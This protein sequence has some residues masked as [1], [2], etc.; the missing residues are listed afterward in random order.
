[1]KCVKIADTRKLV[2]S[3]ME[4]N[5]NNKDEVVGKVIKAGICGSDIHYWDIGNP[6]GLVMGHEFCCE[7]LRPGNRY[8]LKVGDRFTA[9]P[10]SPCGVCEACQSGNPQ[11]CPNT[12]HDAVGL[13]LS[14]PGAFSNMLS[15][16]SDLVIKVPD[17]VNDNEVA[18]VEPTAVGY[19]A[20]NLAKI[21]EGSKVL[22]IG[23]GIIGMV[24]AMF[25]KYQ[26]ACFVAVSEANLKRGEKAIKLGVADKYYNALDKDVLQ[27]MLSDTNNYGFD[28]V[29]DC[30]GNAPAVTTAFL[31]VKPGGTVVLVGVS[32]N[33]I[34][35]PTS[36]AVTK[37]LTVLGAIAYKKEEFEDV[38]NMISD[39]KIDVLRF[40]D[41]IVPL[42]KAQE[43]FERLTNGDDDA[44][45]ILVD[46]NM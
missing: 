27:E 5:F 42:E 39:K 17:N 40:V 34:T 44:I 21:K 3:N 32:L 45:K 36:L 13:S 12:W 31:A 25:A 23:A 37:E 38:I 30:C 8:D 29:I 1:M 4:D 26:K 43:S 20:I 46:P 19:H 11:Y 7:V 22:V 15:V 28:Y 10:I 18:M 33:P 14:H 6:N 16:R 41:D 24:S 35:I 9:L 2:V